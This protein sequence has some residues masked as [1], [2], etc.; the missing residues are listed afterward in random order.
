M[1][2]NNHTIVH[3]DALVCSTLVV[4]RLVGVSGWRMVQYQCFERP[5]DKVVMGR[6]EQELE[7]CQYVEAEQPAI[8]SNGYAMLCNV[9][10]LDFP[11]PYHP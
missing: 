10:R 5:L 8:R 2:L 9:T 6:N 4:S 11:R 7:I 1:D 3:I